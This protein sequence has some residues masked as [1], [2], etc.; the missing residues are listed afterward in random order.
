M[1]EYYCHLPETG[2][3]QVLVNNQSPC[4]FIK[5][6]SSSDSVKSATRR[7]LG[8]RTLSSHA[9]DGLY[10]STYNELVN[11]RALLRRSGFRTYE[12]DIAPDRRYLME[13]FI[14]SEISLTGNAEL[15]RDH[16]R[17]INPV[18]HAD[19]CNLNFKVASID[20]ET[21]MSTGKLLSIGVHYWNNNEENQII[22]ILGDGV[23]DNNEI[24]SAPSEPE[25]LKVFF[26][27]IE[28]ADPDI[29]IGWNVIN[30]DLQFLLG[31]CKKF[32]I[33]FQL[34]RNRR[35]VTLR[36]AGPRLFISV[37]GRLVLDGPTVLR[38]AFHSFESYSLENVAQKILGEGKLLTGSGRGDEIDR[39]FKEDVSAF[40]AYNLKDCELVSRIFQ[41]LELIDHLVARSR[42]TGL[43]LDEAGRSTAA[44]DHVYLPRLHRSGYVAA[45]KQDVH[46][47]GAA[48]GGFVLDPLPGIYGSVAVLD[49]QS[50]YPAII[51]TFFIDPL[52]RARAKDTVHVRVPT[53]QH[54]SREEHILPGLIEEL[55]S[56]RAEAKQNSDLNLSQAIKIL[57]NSFYGIM[58]STSCRFYHP[59][60]PS[61]ITGTGQWILKETIKMLEERSFKVLYGD[62]D[63]IFIALAATDEEAAS[64]QVEEVTIELNQL[65]QLRLRQEF[66]LDSHLKLEFEKLYVRFV[67]PLA[68]KSSAGAKKRYAGIVAGKDEKL[69][70]TGLEQVRSDWTR[71]A[72]KFQYELYRRVLR[73]E[74]CGEWIKSFISDLK[75]GN[76]DDQLVYRKRLRK[77][78]TEYTTT[79]PQHVKAARMLLNPGRSISYV[80]SKTGP[81]PL[82][83]SDGD[84]DYEY[85]LKKQI[86]PVADSILPLINQRF[87]DFIT[88]S[89]LDLF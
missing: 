27:W 25:L 65:W 71:L 80:I 29:I 87:S 15:H 36:E 81:V 82:E 45:D 79:I 31:R 6:S 26:A 17:F 49:F 74:E 14:H 73:G 57:M 59:E 77:S 83:L 88:S 62:T 12:S 39:L 20:I 23:S 68:R 41:K 60:L 51:R 22:F 30:F 47:L 4:F 84:F 43:P 18:M 21:S 16:L 58:G 37:P 40:I 56:R 5:R 28:A 2:F 63:S 34:G 78:V 11:G 35:T 19:P 67:L 10:F 48:A 8:L 33:P 38:T 53:G 13:R 7:Q 44:F 85:Y 24:V 86:E 3:A 50:L 52:S 1:L 89:Q 75:A 69:E 42:L 54:F 76:F 32:N 70:F 55:L 66:D 64:R 72:K 61:A 9:V 46:A